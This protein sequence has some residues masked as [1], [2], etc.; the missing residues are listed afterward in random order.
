MPHR[1]LRRYLRHGTLTHL[2]AF[3]AVARLGSFTRAAEELNMAQP[4]VSVQIKKL[5]ATLGVPLFQA[6][7]RRVQMTSA[8]QEL[9]SACHDIFERLGE[10]DARLTGLRSAP[11]GSL[12]VA[13]GTSARSFASRLLGSF[14]ERFPDVE[15][16]VPVHNRDELLNRFAAGADDFY[17]LSA[18]PEGTELVSRALVPT[19]LQVYARIDHPLTRRG[20]LRF[21]DVATQPFLMREPGSGTRALVDALFA[22]H[23][24]TPAIRMELGSNEAIEQAVRDGLGISILSA[25]TVGAD[26]PDS[27]MRALDVEGF[28]LERI[29]HLVYRNEKQLSPWAR[30]FL[31]HLQQPEVLSALRSAAR[32]P[33]AA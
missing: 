33:Q 21:E 23:R 11:P 6:A 30:R 27:G 25:Q 16:V 28:P 5:T 10:V 13:V 19:F 17:V 7:G 20:T 32:T 24:A 26:A 15:I 31:E 9:F 2:A 3:E 14:S 4:T 18:L 1:N 29:W 12:R 22:R 8:G